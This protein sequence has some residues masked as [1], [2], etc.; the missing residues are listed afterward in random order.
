M[1]EDTYTKPVKLKKTEQDGE[2]QQDEPHN[3]HQKESLSRNRCR[4]PIPLYTVTH[5]LNLHAGTRCLSTTAPVRYAVRAAHRVGDE[6]LN[7]AQRRG[8]LD[9]QF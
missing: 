3:V 2:P 6:A 9:A 8:R 4:S 5:S 1:V 7:G